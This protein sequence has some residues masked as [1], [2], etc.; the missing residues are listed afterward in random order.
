MGTMS[1]LLAYAL[2]A[3]YQLISAFA[4]VSFIVS[5]RVPQCRSL[6]PTES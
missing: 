2:D 1:A 5:G 3:H 4:I 6:E